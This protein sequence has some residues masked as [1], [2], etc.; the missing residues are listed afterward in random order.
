MKQPQERSVTMDDRDRRSIAAAILAAA[1]AVATLG[2][3]PA[4]AQ[5][6]KIR[7]NIA[8]LDQTEVANFEHAITILKQRATGEKNWDYWVKV[9]G[10]FDVA[11]CLHGGELIFPWHRSEL[12]YFEKLL[13]ES[14]P[15]RT[16]NVTL[17]YWDLTAVTSGAQ[18]YPAAFEKAGSTLSECHQEGR[19]VPC[20]RESH[21]RGTRPYSASDINNILGLSAWADFGG[22][23]RGKGQLESGPHD[24]IHGTY[25]NGLMGA[26]PTAAADPIFYALHTDLD[27]LWAIWQER[28]PGKDPVQLDKPKWQG[29]VW[30][31]LKPP[32]DTAK[33]VLK[34]SDLGYAYGPADCGK[35][36][37][38]TAGRAESPRA[39]NEE[40]PSDGSVTTLPFKL[41]AGDHSQLRL[42]LADVPVSTP[43]VRIF[44]F[45]H[46]AAEPYKPGD[47]SFADAYLAANLT[48]WQSSDVHHANGAET[49]AAS[50][51]VTAVLFPKQP[52][53][54]AKAAPQ[55]NWVITLVVTPASRAQAGVRAAGRALTFSKA[56]LELGTGRTP[57]KVSLTPK[58]KQE[59]K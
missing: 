50:S 28:N 1:L 6:L 23:V 35:G 52:G 11:H 44:V 38:M 33:A 55:S 25:V 21:P 18:G 34:I 10:D 13:Q 36:E 49:H 19:V 41:P 17:P 53:L 47:R 22:R 12:L 58:A 16:S 43:S 4:A 5:S 24:F 32:F 40:L 48:L 59:G 56:S 37:A 3:V 7:K 46:P 14:D 57:A 26:V 2:A 39:A 27:R 31:Q 54:L 8:C 51:D 9:H 45:L 30:Q 20:E 29:T 15:A 42:L